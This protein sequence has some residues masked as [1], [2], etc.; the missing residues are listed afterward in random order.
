MGK[1][2]MHFGSFEEMLNFINHKETAEELAEYKEEEKP[3]K[4]KKKEA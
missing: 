3:K 4:K 2:I 1:E